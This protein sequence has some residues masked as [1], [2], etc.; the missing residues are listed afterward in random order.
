MLP[1]I[2]MEENKL[3]FSFLQLAIGMIS[4]MKPTC[5]VVNSKRF[6][7]NLFKFFRFSL[8]KLTWQELNIYR[9]H[10]FS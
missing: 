3:N 5:L 8:E 6:K 9:N 2:R 1:C 4:N 7:R 10:A